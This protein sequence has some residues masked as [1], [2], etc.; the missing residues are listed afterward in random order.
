[1]IGAHT[2]RPLVS[3][4]ALKVMLQRARIACLSHLSSFSFERRCSSDWVLG[5]STFDGVRDFRLVLAFAGVRS[6]K[7]NALAHSGY[8]TDFQMMCCKKLLR[9]LQGLRLIAAHIRH[10]HPA[11]D[12]QNW[13]TTV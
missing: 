7:Q 13:S 4:S 9:A 12:E 5:G 6:W 10:V 11:H 2:P 3:L 8:S 1:M